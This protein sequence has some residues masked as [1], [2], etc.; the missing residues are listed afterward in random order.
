MDP[1]FTTK[2]AKGGTGLGLAIVQR[3]V[4]LHKGSV[5]ITSN[6][7]IGTTVQVR[8]PMTMPIDEHTG[9]ATA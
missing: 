4:N 3:I 7:G 2:R 8:L 9:S 5:E 6:E 1:F